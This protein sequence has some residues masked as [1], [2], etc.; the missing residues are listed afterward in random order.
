[1]VELLANTKR[2]KYVNNTS[3]GDIFK[4]IKKLKVLPDDNSLYF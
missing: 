1:M 4:K 2:D 3:D